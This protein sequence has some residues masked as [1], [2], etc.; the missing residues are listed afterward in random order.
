M[1]N[2]FASHE[3]LG[4]LV[5]SLGCIILGWCSYRSYEKWD[6]EKRQS[7]QVKTIWILYATTFAV[8]LDTL[9]NRIVSTFYS[10]SLIYIEGAL[11][12]ISL[13][14]GVINAVY[15]ITFVVK[16]FSIHPKESTLSFTYYFLG[17][18][19]GMVF[20]SFVAVDQKRVL[21][22][23]VVGLFV[24]FVSIITIYYAFI[25]AKHQKIEIIKA[26]MKY[27]GYANLFFF[28]FISSTLMLSNTSVDPIFLDNV[29]RVGQIVHAL[30]MYIAFFKPRWFKKKYDKEISY[31]EKMFQNVKISRP[32]GGK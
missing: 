30:F 26:S 27:Y 16:A 2:L 8:M 18:V 12:S 11:L 4:I 31:I 7:I 32:K 29:L 13:G 24:I 20:I 5:T 3:F 15:A 19:L 6:S 25:S 21:M 22:T 23:S 17:V 10:S 1:A 28:L 9:I 14:L